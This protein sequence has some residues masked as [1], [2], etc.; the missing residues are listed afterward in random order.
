MRAHL[1]KG[2][3]GSGRFIPPHALGA[4]E[5]QKENQPCLKED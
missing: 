3:K 1:I 2:N 5:R 4:I